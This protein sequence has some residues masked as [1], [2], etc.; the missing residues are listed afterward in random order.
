MRRHDRRRRRVR[1]RL[2]P[3]RPGAG[4]RR[5]RPLRRQDGGDA[6]SSDGRPHPNPSR[7]TR[8]A[9]SP[10]AGRR[11]R[12]DARLARLPARRGRR[13][14]GRSR[15][16]RSRRLGGARHDRR[17]RRRH[18][19]R[20]HG[21]AARPLRRLAGRPQGGAAR[22]GRLRG[23]ASPR[24]DDRGR[25]AR[26]LP[27]GRHRLPRHG[28]AG[29]RPPRV[30]GATGHLGGSRGARAHGGARRRLGREV[31]PRR[32]GDR[33]A[34]RDDR[35]PGARLAHGH[36]AALLRARRRAAGLGTRPHRRGG[37][38]RSRSS[39][40]VS[41]ATRRCSSRARRTRASTSSR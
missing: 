33:R 14:W 2:P 26:R 25:D 12:D 17:R 30:G 28:R 13:R 6:L 16:A 19:G 31:D 20:P 29:R 15:A 34:A 11:A 18:P 27:S 5:G 9:R 4:S 35:G 38:P 40:G 23:A 8:R 22:P 24:R 1:G 3:R 41:A 7:S 37:R 36:P 32:A 21:G 10:A 39:T